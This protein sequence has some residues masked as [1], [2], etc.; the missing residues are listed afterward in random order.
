MKTQYYFK[1]FMNGNLVGETATA[2]KKAAKEWL[3][4]NLT[5]THMGE[6][7]RVGSRYG[8]TYSTTIGRTYSFVREAYAPYEDGEAWHA[9]S[10]AMRTKYG[11][12]YNM[13]ELFDVRKMNQLEKRAYWALYS[14]TMLARGVSMEKLKTTELFKKLFPTPTLR[15]I[16]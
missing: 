13:R 14:S 1:I 2:T 10:A 11:T 3:K 9:L 12:D 4:K 8:W 5:S 16:S 15:L 6:W 7:R